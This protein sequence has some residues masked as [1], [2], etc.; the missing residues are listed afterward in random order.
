M[1][2]HIRSLRD[3][4]AQLN[5]IGDLQAIDHEVDWN[6]EMGAIARRSMDLRA[7]APLF[8]RIRGIVP[9]FRAFGAPGGL[10]ANPKYKYARVNLALGLPADSPPLGIVRALA[11]ARSR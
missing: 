6:L 9:G 2:N 10:S 5:A 7:P 3:F 11:D 4:L 8:N 1:P